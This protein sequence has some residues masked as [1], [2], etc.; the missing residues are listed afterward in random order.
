MHL[1]LLNLLNL[2]NL[3]EHLCSAVCMGLKNEFQEIYVYTV[4]CVVGPHNTLPTDIAQVSVVRLIEL[5]NSFNSA[6][7]TACNRQHVILTPDIYLAWLWPLTFSSCQWRPS[8]KMGHVGCQHSLLRWHRVRPY[9]GFT[10]FSIQRVSA[11]ASSYCVTRQTVLTKCWL[12]PLGKDKKAPWGR[13]M[14]V[15][16][17]VHSFYVS[18]SVYRFE[19]CEIWAFKPACWV[20]LLKLWCVKPGLWQSFPVSNI[21]RSH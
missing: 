14:I 16:P 20:A 15:L 17:V 3:R 19:P 2:E 9:T 5:L 21:T 4:F 12:Q 11:S 6:S 13:G 7:F 8:S 10:V 1:G 18:V